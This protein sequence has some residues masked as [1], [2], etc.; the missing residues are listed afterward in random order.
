MKTKSAFVTKILL[1]LIPLVILSSCARNSTE[2]VVESDTDQYTIQE[3]YMRKAGTLN[4]KMVWSANNSGIKWTHA[5][6]SCEPGS[7]HIYVKMR[8]Y[9][10]ITTYATS[11][12][13][14]TIS[15]GESKFVYVRGLQ[16]C[17]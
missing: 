3:V 14:V 15:E 6:I 4:Y 16:I 9:D 5:N 1:L 17:Q 13:Y 10:L 8:Y 2:L 11:I 12:S 7:Y